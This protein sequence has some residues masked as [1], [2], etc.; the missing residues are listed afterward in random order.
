M[1]S[2]YFET[3]LFMVNTYLLFGNYLP[4]TESTGEVEGGALGDRDPLGKTAT[5]DKRG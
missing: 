1:G 2:R 4:S 3:N 5:D